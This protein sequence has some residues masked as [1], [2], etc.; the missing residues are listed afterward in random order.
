MLGEGIELPLPKA[1]VAGD[2]VGSLLHRSGNEAAAAYPAVLLSKEQP[3]I[4]EDPQVFRNGGKG[5]VERLCELGHRRFAPSQARKNCPPGRV[6][7]GGEG[8]VK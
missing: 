3:R 7:Q 2:P 8:P 1:S 5:H 6:R 4:F